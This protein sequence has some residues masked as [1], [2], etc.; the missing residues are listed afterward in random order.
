MPD[1]QEVPEGVL[2]RVGAVRPGTLLAAP[3]WR[4]LVRASARDRGLDRA[5]GRQALRA[6]LAPLT[7]GR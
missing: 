7:A 5:R 3:F 1:P 6:A 2:E 4:P